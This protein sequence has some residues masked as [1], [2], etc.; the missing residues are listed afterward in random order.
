MRGTILKDDSIRKVENR[1]SKER[2]NFTSWF[3]VRSWHPKEDKKVMRTASHE[4]MPRIRRNKQR[5]GK[6]SN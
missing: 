5:L 3:S 1:C 4:T 6:V 2:N